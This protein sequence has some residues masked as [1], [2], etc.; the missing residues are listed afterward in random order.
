[1]FIN[2]RDVAVLRSGVVKSRSLCF[3]KQSLTEKSKVWCCSF[4]GE[5]D[6]IL[7]V[8]KVC[9]FGFFKPIFFY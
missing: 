8:L 2:V 6:F 3:L 4:E 5:G 9:W 7:T 1:M